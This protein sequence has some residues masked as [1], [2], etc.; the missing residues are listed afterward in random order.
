MIF[1]AQDPREKRR[2]AEEDR[3]RAALAEEE[4]AGRVVYHSAD[5]MAGFGGEYTISTVPAFTE[6]AANDAR[7]TAGKPSD[8]ESE[9]TSLEMKRALRPPGQGVPKPG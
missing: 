8:T 2:R 7:E 5:D 9:T 1:A 3:R 6:A 4:K